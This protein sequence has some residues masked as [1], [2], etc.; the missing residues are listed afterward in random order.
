MDPAEVAALVIF[1]ATFS[2][3]SAGR[4]ARGRI[5]IPVIAVAGGAAMIAAGILSPGGALSSISWGTLE[6]ILGMMLLASALEASG[7]FELVSGLIIRASSTPSL[8]LVVVS[9]VTAFLSALILNDAVV[10]LLTPVIISSARRMGISPVPPLVLEALSSNIGGAATEV[11]NPQN[12]YIA[13]ASGLGFAYFTSRLLPVAALSLIAAIVAVMLLSG[14]GYRSLSAAAPEARSHALPPLTGKIAVMLAVVASVFTLFYALPHSYL[15]ATALSGGLAAALLSTVTSKGGLR[16]VAGGVDWGILAFFGGL[17]VLIGGVES[18]GLLNLIISSLVGVDPHLLN[19]PG[20][21]AL[22]SAIL[23][24]L[25]S[26]VP[27]VLLIAHVM[28]NG[29]TPLLWL[30]LSSSSTLAGNAT[31]LGAAANVIVVRRASREGLPIT[32]PAF[33]KYGLPVTLVSLA[34]A[35]FFLA[36]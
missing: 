28:G 27:A 24:N 14:R 9:L 20:G 30:T 13:G 4:A 2:L 7:F 32:L 15:P 22:L 25:V 23:S 6:L 1:V 34:I 18:S 21:V 12:A 19:S 8:F 26:N 3:I 11:G 29:T 17:F 31:I 10:L 35:L 5:G 16:R 33:A 36:A